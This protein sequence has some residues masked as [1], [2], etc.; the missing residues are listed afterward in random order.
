MTKFNAKM[1]PSDKKF[2]IVVLSFFVAIFGG[3]IL[4]LLDCGGPYLS[5]IG[6][7]GNGLS[8]I[9]MLVFGIAGLVCVASFLY[10][11]HDEESENDSNRTPLG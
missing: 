7:I 3:G 11:I 8:T 6:G 2:S 9:G 4:I 10:P 5:C 1:T